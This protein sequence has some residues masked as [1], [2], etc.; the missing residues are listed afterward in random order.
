M[1]PC[2]TSSFRHCMCVYTSCVSFVCLLTFTL[3][4][5]T[6]PLPYK[7][8]RLRF[9]VEVVA[10]VQTCFQVVFVPS[11]LR[12]VAEKSMFRTQLT[13]A[14]ASHAIFRNTGL[15]GGRNVGVACTTPSML[16]NAN[17]SPRACPWTNLSFLSYHAVFILINYCFLFVHCEPFS[18]LVHQINLE[19]VCVCV[20]TLSCRR[21]FMV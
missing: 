3:Y 8:Y 10:G 5:L 20:S 7:I 13:W 12:R 2:F 18:I 11:F 9:Q 21:R 14:K 17:L 6:C 4:V 16:S 15:S 19:D 1:C